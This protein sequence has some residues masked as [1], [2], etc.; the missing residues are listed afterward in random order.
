MEIDFLLLDLT[1]EFELI[2][3]GGFVKDIIRNWE[4]FDDDDDDDLQIYFDNPRPM[5]RSHLLFDLIKLIDSRKDIVC[6]MKSLKQS[7]LKV[8]DNIPF[9]NITENR[10]YQNALHVVHMYD[11]LASIKY[12]ESR[13]RPFFL[14][15]RKFL[16]DCAKFLDQQ[17]REKR[18]ELPHVTFPELSTKETGRRMAIITPTKKIPIAERRNFSRTPIRTKRLDIIT[19][20]FNEPISSSSMI[21]PLS[22]ARAS[23]PRSPYQKAQITNKFSTSKKTPTKSPSLRKSWV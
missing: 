12:Q 9:D 3:N 14:R 7:M 22:V 20:S 2:V 17:D 8:F 23:P 5:F 10:I 21:S 1:K 11:V 15:S 18:K 19:M 4:T 16:I 13:F 6:A